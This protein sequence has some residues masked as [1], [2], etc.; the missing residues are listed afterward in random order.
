MNKTN[1]NGR[2]RSQTHIYELHNDG[3]RTHTNWSEFYSGPIRKYTQVDVGGC[4]SMCEGALEVSCTF[5]WSVKSNEG[6]WWRS[7]GTPRTCIISDH[8][9]NHP[10]QFR[11]GRRCAN[12][13][14]KI[15]AYGCPMKRSELIL[16]GISAG[17]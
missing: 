6:K 13:F 3:R 12:N 4:S 8:V 14:T 1:W 10:R 5:R 15:R 7:T 2:K 9:R 17:L 11:L 16:Y